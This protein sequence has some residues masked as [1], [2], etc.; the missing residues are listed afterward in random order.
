MR[1]FGPVGDHCYGDTI[2]K[3]GIVCVAIFLIEIDIRQK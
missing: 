2:D 3:T 1:L